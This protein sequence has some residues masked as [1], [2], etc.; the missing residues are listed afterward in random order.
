MRARGSPRCGRISSAGVTVCGSCL[1]R[2]LILTALSLSGGICCP[3]RVFDA[4]LLRVTVFHIRGGPSVVNS[5]VRIG[6]SACRSRNVV[7][8]VV[9]SRH[10]TNVTRAVQ[11]RRFVSVLLEVD[12]VLFI[13]VAATATFQEDSCGDDEADDYQ[14]N[15]EESSGN[16]TLVIKEAK[17]APLIRIKRYESNDYNA[18]RATAGSS[19]N[20]SA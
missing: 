13:A 16:G 12:L 8:T 9:R 7:Y 10:S 19:A 3:R 18:R 5:A 2:V 17:M 1:T 4:V 15:T 6:V 14:T 11:N 20:R